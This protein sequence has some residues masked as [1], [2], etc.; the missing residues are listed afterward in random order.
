MSASTKSQVLSSF[1]SS[2]NKN[3]T[4]PKGNKPSGPLWLSLISSL[5]EPGI[6]WRKLS[7][8]SK[9]NNSKMIQLK[10]PCPQAINKHH[11]KLVPRLKDSRESKRNKTLN[12][13]SCH[14]LRKNLNPK[15]KNLNPEDNLE[16][17]EFKRQSKNKR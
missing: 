17:N 16:P 7:R 4:A 12:L 8:K 11:P 5:K 15:L 2:T 10:H 14:L 9:K 1:N 6:I 13:D 3:K